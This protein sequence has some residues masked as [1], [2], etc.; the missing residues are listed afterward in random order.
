MSACRGYPPTQ[1]KSE[2]WAEAGGGFVESPGA[3]FAGTITIGMKRASAVAI[4][5]LAFMG[6]SCARR[7]TTAR[8][9]FVP[10]TPSPAPNVSPEAAGALVVAEPQLPEPEPEPVPPA[11]ETA[12]RPRSHPRVRLAPPDPSTESEPESPPAPEVPALEP[13]EGPAEQSAQRQQVVQFLDQIRRRVTRQEQSNLSSD[14]RRML[15]DARTFVSSPSAPLPPATFSA[16][17]PSH[18]KRPCYSRFL[19]SNNGQD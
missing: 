15:G 14:E 2:F 9:V 16:P 13:R 5:V 3:S 1:S 4:C 6:V 8:I 12:E 17:A 19:N 7:Q 11:P 10:S 18:A